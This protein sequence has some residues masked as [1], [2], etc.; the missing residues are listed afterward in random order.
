VETVAALINLPT[1]I[2]IGIYLQVEG[3]GKLVRPQPVE[4]TTM[5]KWN[6]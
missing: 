5:T 1:L 4:G 2:V 3:I 6:G